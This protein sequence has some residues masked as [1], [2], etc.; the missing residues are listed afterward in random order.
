MA[1]RSLCTRGRCPPFQGRATRFGP[2]TLAGTVFV[3]AVLNHH[4]V[5]VA[6][7]D[8]PRDAPVRLTLLGWLTRVLRGAFDDEKGAQAGAL[9]RTRCTSV[10]Q[11]EARSGRGDWIRTSDPLRPRQA[12]ERPVSHSVETRCARVNFV[13]PLL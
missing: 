7:F 5:P 12:T 4:G 2:E 1:Y 13:G 3:H 8:S 10:A 11:A 6:V 9:S